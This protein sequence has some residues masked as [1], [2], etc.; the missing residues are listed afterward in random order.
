MEVSAKLQKK[1]DAF[2]AT[3]LH[4]NDTKRAM[5]GM[6]YQLRAQ[7]NADY[8]L[9]NEVS[10]KLEAEEVLLSTVPVVQQNAPIDLTRVV[11]E[12]DVPMQ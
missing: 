7:Q 8:K 12:D 6:E 1:V 5:Q 3:L 9:A 10:L 11:A 2:V 4:G